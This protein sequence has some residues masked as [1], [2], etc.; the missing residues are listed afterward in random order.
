ME[1]N[2]H[3]EAVQDA[4]AEGFEQVD[5]EG[6]VF[7]RSSGEVDAQGVKEAPDGDDPTKDESAAVPMY[8]GPERHTH[9]AH[10][11]EARDATVDDADFD[12]EERDAEDNA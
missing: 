6:H 7:A 10:E 9:S 2:V 4:E 1:E 8:V 5:K 3:E 11:E 12:A